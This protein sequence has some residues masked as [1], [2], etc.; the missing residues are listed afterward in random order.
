MKIP[1]GMFKQIA[2]GLFKALEIP[3]KLLT[4]ILGVRTLIIVGLILVI[5][6]LLYF[7]FGAGLRNGSG[8]ESGDGNTEMVSTVDD[9]SNLIPSD[10]KNNDKADETTTETKSLS[11][12]VSD[13][14]YWFNNN[15]VSLEEIILIIKKDE[16]EGYKV[17]I[18]DD[19]ASK[20]AYDD[21][22]NLLKEEGIQYEEE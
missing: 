4:R 3:F 16:Y 15:R 11:I 20:N 18:K 2:K 21:I 1:T 14:D 5:A 9:P 8:D 12:T 10:T 22:I 6:A 13:N 19:N 7:G 17:H